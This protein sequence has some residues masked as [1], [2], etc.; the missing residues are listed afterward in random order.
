MAG[1]TLAQAY[2]IGASR[3]G[4]RT[5]VSEEIVGAKPSLQVRVFVRRYD[6]AGNVTGVASIPIDGMDAVPHDFITVTGDGV[7][8]VLMRP[9]A[10]SRSV[11]SN[12]RPCRAKA[13]G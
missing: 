12:C 1:G 5:V 10:A 4:T 13:G 7:V 2:E 3:D 6:R 9:K 8:R 11:R